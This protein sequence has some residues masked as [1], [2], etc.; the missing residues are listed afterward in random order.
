M[1]KYFFR[2]IEDPGAHIS[3]EIKLLLILGL[4]FTFIL[5]YKLQNSKKAMYIGL[6][7]SA[8]NQIGL[9]LWYAF[10]KTKFLE[11][12]LPLYHCRIAAIGMI[13]AYILK[14]QK[15]Q[16][17][18]ALIGLLGG[19]VAFMVPDIEPF[20]FPHFTNFA[21]VFGHYFILFC[22]SM[23]LFSSQG[24]DGFYILKKTCLMNLSILVVDLAFD[25]N[26]AYLLE[27]P[28]ILKNINFEPAINT[29][30]VSSMLFFM[31]VL[32]NGISLQLKDKLAI[33]E[34]NEEDFELKES[35]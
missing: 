15:A 3:S 25:V 13:I 22:A 5:A 17:Y 12:G 32:L 28:K 9:F 34:E 27:L 16:N 19:F 4:I 1:F 2:T 31:L 30:V 29:L 10:T 24:L 21:F 11:F 7:L 20:L 33:L 14:K 6:S 23:I 35:I 26:Y 8:F 18:F